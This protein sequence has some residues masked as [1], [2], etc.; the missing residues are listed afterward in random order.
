MKF[1]LSDKNSIILQIGDIKLSD[2]GDTFGK[3]RR[4]DEYE[5]NPLL[6][7]KNSILFRKGIIANIGSNGSYRCGASISDGKDSVLLTYVANRITSNAESMAIGFFDG[8][9][10]FFVDEFFSDIYGENP[11]LSRRDIMVCKS[12]WEK[13][14]KKKVIIYNGEIDAPPTKKEVDYFEQLMGRVERLEP[15]FEKEKLRTLRP[16]RRSSTHDER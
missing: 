2:T 11:E 14:E 1:D 12:L 7:P 15:A 9:Q 3:T 16:S 10:Y 4:V 5:Y 13:G 8:E 6:N